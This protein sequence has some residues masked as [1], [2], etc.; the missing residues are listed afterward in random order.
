MGPFAANSKSTGDRL[1][2]FIFISTGLHSCYHAYFRH[3]TD[4]KSNNL[5]SD[6]EKDVYKLMKGIDNRLKTLKATKTTVVF[7]TEGRLYNLFTTDP[8]MQNEV[9]ECVWRFNRH[10]ARAAHEFGYAVLEV[11]T[12]L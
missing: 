4:S 10:L 11:L 3:S 12:A 2:D 7:V 1:P 8:S 9:D 5:V 6:H